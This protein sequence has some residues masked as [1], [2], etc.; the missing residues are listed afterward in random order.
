MLSSF[1]GAVA[2]YTLARGRDRFGQL[3]ARLVGDDHEAVPLPEVERR[4]HEH[5]RRVRD[6][7][8]RYGS[9]SATR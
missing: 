8:E 6:V 1:C 7:G 9:H 5:V 3:D 4:R 2:M